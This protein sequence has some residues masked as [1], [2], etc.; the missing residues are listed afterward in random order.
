MTLCIVWFVTPIIF[1]T[2]V[3]LLAAYKLNKIPWPQ[4]AEATAPAPPPKDYR[5]GAGRLAGAGYSAGAGT[6]YSPGGG[7]TGSPAPPT[8]PRDYTAA[9]AVSRTTI[10][11][12]YSGAPG[13][14]PYTPGAPGVQPYTPGA[15]GVQP[16]TLSSRP[17]AAIPGEEAT[18]CEIP[19]HTQVHRCS[20]V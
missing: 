16:Y 14:Q 3:G 6:L 7:F 2:Q 10:S 1:H 20:L 8:P 18:Y 9:P 13:L 17:R 15:P 5:S 12:P 19:A 4:K 11:L